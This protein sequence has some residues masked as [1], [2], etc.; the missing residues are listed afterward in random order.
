MEEAD[1]QA[2]AHADANRRNIEA[3]R[4]AIEEAEQCLAQADRTG[5]WQRWRRRNT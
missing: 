2:A 4:A 5:G 1:A 3:A